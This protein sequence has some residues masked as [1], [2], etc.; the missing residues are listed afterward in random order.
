MFR[1]LDIQVR[2]MFVSFHSACICLGFTPALKI[3]HLF[4]SSFC[5][6]Q[7]VGHLNIFSLNFFFRVGIWLLVFK[8]FVHL[9]ITENFI[10]SRAS[11]LQQAIFK[12]ASVFSVF[13]CGFPLPGNSRGNEETWTWTCEVSGC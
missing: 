8:Y 3:L 13:F 9:I 11:S 6:F 10:T 1:I 12:D 4:N 2:S 5:S 7:G